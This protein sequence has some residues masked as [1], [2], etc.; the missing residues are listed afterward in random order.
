[1]IIRIDNIIPTI[2]NRISGTIED[3]FYSIAYPISR[4]NLKHPNIIHGI[5]DKKF[6]MNV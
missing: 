1:M 4:H 2:I 5:D 3:V 6:E